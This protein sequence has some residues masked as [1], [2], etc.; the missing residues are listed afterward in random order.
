VVEL[1]DAHALAGALHRQQVGQWAGG[2]HHA[3]GVHRKIA[4]HALQRGGLF[5]HL[6]VTWRCIAAFHLPVGR[7]GT[8]AGVFLRFSMPEEIRQLRGEL[9]NFGGREAVRLGYIRKG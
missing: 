4:R 1:S 3:A 7:T 9:A 2:D 8:R 6:F 5:E